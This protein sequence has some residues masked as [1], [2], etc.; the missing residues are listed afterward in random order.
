[1]YTNRVFGT[2]KCVLFIKVSISRE[3]NVLLT[4]EIRTGSVLTGNI[5][6]PNGIHNRGSLRWLGNRVFVFSKRRLNLHN[7]APKIRQ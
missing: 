7:C 2:V 1:M 3:N 4:P 5:S 6:P